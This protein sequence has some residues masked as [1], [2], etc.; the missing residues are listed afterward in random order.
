[1]TSPT[2]PKGYTWQENPMTG[3]MTLT[4]VRIPL[5]MDNPFRGYDGREYHTLEALQEANRDYLRQM[6]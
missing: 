4:L 2:D 1:M 3:K 6:L 5:K